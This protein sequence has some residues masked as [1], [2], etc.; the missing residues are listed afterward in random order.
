LTKRV[1]L[2]STYTDT[3]RF[4]RSAADFQLS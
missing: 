3:A 1:P 2:S 4:L